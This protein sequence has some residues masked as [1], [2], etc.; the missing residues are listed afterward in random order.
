MASMAEVER[1]GRL[2]AAKRRR[3]RVAKRPGIVDAKVPTNP[4]SPELPGVES[5]PGRAGR[6]ARRRIARNTTGMGATR[7][8]QRYPGSVTPTPVR[9]R[10][11]REGRVRRAIRTLSVPHVNA[12]ASQAQI[13][14]SKKVVNTYL[15]AQ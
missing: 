11:R 5:L 12:R 4:K 13:D 14:A 10:I 6:Q 2:N 7:V 8:R 9:A 1:L 3:Q 15:A